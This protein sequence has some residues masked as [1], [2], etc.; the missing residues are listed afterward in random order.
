MIE[1]LA[2]HGVMAADLVP[3]LMT[4]HTVRNPEYDPA[5]ARA[6][7]EENEIAEE[8]HDGVEESLAQTDAQYSEKETFE[9]TEQKESSVAILEHNDMPRFS[10][11][12][13]FG[14]EEPLELAPPPYEAPKPRREKLGKN[15]NPFGDDED[16]DGG[17]I[18]MLASPP[19][20]TRSVA[21]T[22]QVLPDVE[23]GDIAATLEDMK[24][25]DDRTPTASL[26][27]TRGV[28]TLAQTAAS[29]A[30]AEAKPTNAAEVVKQGVR[31]E[32]P[33]QSEALPGVSTALSKT[34]QNVTLDIRWT[35]V[36][37]E[38]RCR[39]NNL[40]S[41]TEVAFAFTSYVICS[42]S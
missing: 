22:A 17:D 29:E 37:A 32:G 28:S 2:E 33:K 5:A 35:V 7:P 3:A 12:D 9:D 14:Q 10:P 18:T 6:I 34:D 8:E 36:S 19:V 38:S 27:P 31:E 24:V 41:F 23:E 20:Q 13:P 39:E 16:S 21:V 11:S 26:S 40:S 1:S 30:K 42:Y 15:V 4:T 25:S